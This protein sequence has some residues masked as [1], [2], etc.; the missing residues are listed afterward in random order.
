MKR[1][2]ACAALLLVSAVVA[3]LL[4]AADEI[5]VEAPAPIKGQV[6]YD[7]SLVTDPVTLSNGHREKLLERLKEKV[8]SMD[9]EQVQQALESIEAEMN[10]IAAAQRLKQ[11]T[12][13]LQSIVDDYANTTSGTRAANMLRANSDQ[14]FC[15]MLPYGAM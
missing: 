8:A 1:L 12:A 13:L 11:A 6:A 14:P 5:R 4:R 10:E 2:I 9:D 7:K 3:S 15:E